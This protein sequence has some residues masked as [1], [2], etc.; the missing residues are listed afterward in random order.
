MLKQL[1]LKP[2]GAAKPP[3]LADFIAAHDR[4]KAETAS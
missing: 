3:S 2:A 1:G 4:A